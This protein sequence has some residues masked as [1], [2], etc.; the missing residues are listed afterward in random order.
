[1]SSESLFTGHSDL[2]T[3]VHFSHNGEYILTGSR[4]TTVRLWSLK[5]KQLDIYTGHS[6]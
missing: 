1:M 5:G 4:D 3:S 6:T 2:I